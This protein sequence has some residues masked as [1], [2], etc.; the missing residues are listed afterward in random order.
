M[1]FGK[2]GDYIFPVIVI[3]VY[4][5][6]IEIVFG[7]YS[8]SV[9]ISNGRMLHPVFLSH[10]L[11][12][13]NQPD[14][15][16][17]YWWIIETYSWDQ[18]LFSIHFLQHIYAHVLLILCIQGWFLVWFLMGQMTVAMLMIVWVFLVIFY[19]LLEP[20][21]KVFPIWNRRIRAYNAAILFQRAI[22][23]QNS[24]RSY[25]EKDNYYVGSPKKC[26]L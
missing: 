6:I 5:L 12:W 19:R 2:Y 11:G 18:N 7:Y 17:D 25:I 23:I 9:V 10:Y 16:S 26:T 21:K 8:P 15:P 14:P 13:F 4:R 20:V 1:V 22:T 24:N 3:W